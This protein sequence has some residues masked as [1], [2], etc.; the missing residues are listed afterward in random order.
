MNKCEHP[1][2]KT[3]STETKPL[4]Y[5]SNGVTWLCFACFLREMKRRATKNF[6]QLELAESLRHFSELKNWNEL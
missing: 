3:E 2:C 1:K 5:G 4:N 6:H